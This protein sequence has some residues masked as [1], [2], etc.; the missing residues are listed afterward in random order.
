MEAEQPIAWLRDYRQSTE[1]G[2][3]KLHSIRL[4]RCW[5]PNTVRFLDLI[6]LE[7]KKKREGKIKKTLEIG[8][9]E[10]RKPDR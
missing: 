7:K 2:V 8:I 6:V 3:A 1:L 5:K 10:I 9:W 4:I